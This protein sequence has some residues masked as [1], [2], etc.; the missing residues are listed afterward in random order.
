M[1]VISAVH[2]L[3]HVIALS[4]LQKLCDTN[5]R[6]LQLNGKYMEKNNCGPFG[7][8]I[9]ALALEWGIRIASL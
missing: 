5:G 4:Q 3:T 7:G 6:Q 2:L 8:T 1:A 9:I